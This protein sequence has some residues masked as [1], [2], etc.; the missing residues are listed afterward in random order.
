MT[1]HLDEM[2]HYI[3]LSESTITRS[4]EG[5][6]V[7]DSI[8]VLEDR[9]PIILEDIQAILFKLQSHRIDE[10]STEFNE[11]LEEGIILA[12]NMLHRILERHSKT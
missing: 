1:G 4:F 11:G 8:E 2:R 12:S 3:Q 10:A 6:V 9:T 7:E 5:T